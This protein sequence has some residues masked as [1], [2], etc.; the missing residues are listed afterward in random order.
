MQGNGALSGQVLNFG[1]AEFTQSLTVD[2]SG[3][4]SFDVS[5]AQFQATNVNFDG[6]AVFGTL[7][8]QN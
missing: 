4:A 3:E 5:Q 8:F 2:Y 6:L 1:Q 7:G